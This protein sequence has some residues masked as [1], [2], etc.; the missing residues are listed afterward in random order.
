MGR[1][2]AHWSHLSIIQTFTSLTDSKAMCGDPCLS[3]GIK[4]SGD[5][6]VLSWTM[7]PDLNES[8]TLREAFRQVLSKR[9]MARKY[10]KLL[11]ATVHGPPSSSGEERSRLNLGIARVVAMRF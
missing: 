2:G 1:C 6:L 5:L 3:L 4:Q 9:Q 10:S 11:I 7:Y 8:V